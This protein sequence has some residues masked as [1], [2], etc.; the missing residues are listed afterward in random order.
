MSRN[1]RASQSKK[2]PLPVPPLSQP[3][4]SR[5]IRPKGSLWTAPTTNADKESL[6]D[7]FCKVF[8]DA[9]RL[10]DKVVDAEESG[11]AKVGQL[12][13]A[14]LVSTTSSYFPFNHLTANL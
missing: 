3:P 12:F 8:D 2:A 14:A 13:F 6:Q 7:E 11:Q 5:S 1:T 9:A 4:P 10:K